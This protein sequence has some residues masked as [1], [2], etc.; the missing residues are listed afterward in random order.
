MNRVVNT[1]EDAST[2]TSK[3]QKSREA[4][5]NTP[6]KE[7]SNSYARKSAANKKLKERARCTQDIAQSSGEQ[8]SS[9]LGAL[10]NDNILKNTSITDSL[11]N[12][13]GGVGALAA[14][15][16]GL[17]SKINTLRHLSAF[18]GLGA[19]GGLTAG[20]LLGGGA[21]GMLAGGSALLKLSHGVVSN[22]I[23]FSACNR[24]SCK[25]SR[26]RALCASKCGDNPKTVQNCL[27]QGD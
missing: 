7:R 11:T 3:E 18:G 24:A 15:A 6:H 5:T 19:L 13:S 1:E 25:S 14:G 4:S 17:G 8:S 12:A 22:S 10:A 26:I 21:L 23:C 20:G 27:A 2:Q 16:M 9:M